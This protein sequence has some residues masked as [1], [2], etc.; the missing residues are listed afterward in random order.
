MNELLR[1]IAVIAH[2]TL[3]LLTAVFFALPMYLFIK[4][5]AY[6]YGTLALIGWFFLIALTVLMGGATKKEN[7]SAGWTTILLVPWAVIMIVLYVLVRSGALRGI[8]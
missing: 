8:G 6:F 4:Y 2:I 3:Y 1:G 7:F 5:G